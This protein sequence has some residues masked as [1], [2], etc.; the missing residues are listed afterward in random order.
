M[1]NSLSLQLAKSAGGV[2]KTYYGEVRSMTGAGE[3]ECKASLFFLP[4]FTFF[5]S[6]FQFALKSS[7]SYMMIQLSKC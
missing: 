5:I 3:R 2:H 1:L 6:H 4:I 7:S